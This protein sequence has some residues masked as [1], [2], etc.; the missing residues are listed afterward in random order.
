MTPCGR[1]GYG[2]RTRAWAI[3]PPLLRRRVLRTLAYRYAQR[4]VLDGV[5]L[6]HRWAARGGPAAEL[7]EHLARTVARAAA[8]FA[9]ELS[10]RHASWPWADALHAPWLVDDA[11]GVYAGWTV[12]RS[13][14]VT[15]RLTGPARLGGL[16]GHHVPCAAVRGSVRHVAR[17]RP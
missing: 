9:C 3:P 11:S 12:W 15:G 4:S 1:C 14:A 8:A 16:G 7:P 13:R 17:S 6:W 2:D 5:P 10:A